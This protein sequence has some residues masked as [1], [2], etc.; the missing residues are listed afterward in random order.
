MNVMATVRKAAARPAAPV[1]SKP[2]PPRGSLYLIHGEDDY[3][4]SEEARRI[5]RSLTPAGA[6]D[7]A[8]ETIEGAASNQ[9]EAA[10]MFGRLFETL[11]TRSFFATDRVVWWRD[12]NL[13][14]AGATATGSQVAEFLQ[15]LD[16]LIQTGLPPGTSLVITASDC[17]GRRSIVKRLEQTGQVISFKS[18]PYRREELQGRLAN[19]AREVASKNQ[20]TLEEEPALLIAEMAGGDSRTVHSEVEKIAAFVGDAP[21]I[22]EEDIRQ[23]G[24][25]RPGGV[26]WELADAVG[27]RDLSRALTALDR[28][29]FA[30]EE[31]IP[32]LFTIVSRM[33]QLLLLRTLMD[34]KLMPSGANF[35]SFKAK[36]ESLPASITEKLPRER[37]LNPLAGH[38]YALWKASAGASRF[39][40]AEL[41]DALSLL[42]DYNEQM[43]S[44]GNPRALLEDAIMQICIRN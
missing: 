21:R 43:V 25:W 2:A 26:V 30:G 34:Q 1:K 18:D 40:S 19:L 41:Q 24:S 12:T 9:D 32:L 5:I 11:Q 3:L 42:A 8:I 37:K 31:P 23:V 14:G 16:E 20:K 7:F 27:E 6:S 15:A 4:V 36:L 33:R 22:T 10:S 44:G 39:T 13:L 35:N 28:L 38:P 29:L 17:D